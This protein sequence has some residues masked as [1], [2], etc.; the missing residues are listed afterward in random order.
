MAKTKEITEFTFPCQ[1]ALKAM[2]L[3]ETEFQTLILEIVQQHAPEVT[4]AHCSCK[5]SKN[6]KYDSVTITFEAQSKKQ[7]DQIYQLLTD[8]KKVLF[9]L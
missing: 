5:S 9:T 8:H 7:M 1:F 6:G 4:P 2:G 3:A